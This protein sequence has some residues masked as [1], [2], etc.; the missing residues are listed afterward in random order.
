M[1]AILV[2]SIWMMLAIGAVACDLFV[3]VND[4]AGGNGPRGSGSTGA[5]GSGGTISV[6]GG[7]SGFDLGDELSDVDNTPSRPAPT[8]G[9]R[10]CSASALEF[11]QS[12]CAVQECQAGEGCAAGGAA[13][14]AGAAGGPSLVCP[15]DFPAFTVDGNGWRGCHITDVCKETVA[16]N[17]DGECCYRYDYHCL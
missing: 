7:G 3:G 4:V 8:P 6:S 13:G 15:D 16:A 5:Q 2:K 11:W 14:A 9:Y 1:Q 10:L 12:S 17:A